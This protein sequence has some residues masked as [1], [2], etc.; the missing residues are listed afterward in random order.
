MTPKT[1]IVG[2]NNPHSS[3]ADTALLPMPKNSAGWRLWKMHNDVSGVSRA[4]HWR[5]F[6][7]VNACDARLWDP[8]AARKKMAN[9]WNSWPGRRVILCGRSLLDTMWLHRPPALAWHRDDG[10]TWCYI[11][12][13]SGLSREYNDDRLR[14]AV[15]MRLMEECEDET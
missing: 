4:E 5:G 15:G 14:A 6:E 12:H 7:F 2:M 9:L 13:P 11:P 3:R 10:V 8:Y 1:I